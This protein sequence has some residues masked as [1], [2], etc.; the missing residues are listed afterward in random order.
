MELSVNDLIGLFKLAS[1]GKVTG[2]LIHNINGPLQNIGLDLEMS[3]YMLKKETDDNSGIENNIMVRLKRIEDELDRLNTMIKT[4]SNR[5]MHAD[6]G[7]QNF[8]EYLDQELSFLNS[9]LYYKHNVETTLKLDK[10]P[11]LVCHLPENAVLAFGWLLQMVIEE[12]EK[13]KKNSLFIRTEKEG[14]LLKIFVSA[15]I[16]G[17]PESINDI[18]KSI[19]LDSDNLTV[20]NN[21]SDLMLILKIFHSEGILI[22]IEEGTEATISICFPVRD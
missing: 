8:N 11:P 6:N 10:H 19:D 17:L 15:E 1:L 5:V 16:A 20:P 22:K 18:Y 7:F 14:G 3:Q 21:Q 2:G 4:S 12:V 13:L 9:N